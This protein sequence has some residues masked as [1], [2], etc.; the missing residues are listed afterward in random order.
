MSTNEHGLTRA[1]PEIEQP[2]MDS[3]TMGMKTVVT[4][5]PSPSMIAGP[6]AQFDSDLQTNLT[7]EPNGKKVQY[8]Q[9]EHAP[10]L[11]DNQAVCQ[12]VDQDQKGGDQPSPPLPHV[13]YEIGLEER[14][15]PE[16]DTSLA[17]GDW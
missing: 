7:G 12:V 17:G 11:L 13:G 1:D 5:G 8:L 9:I 14:P 16:R 4:E 6:D 3:C 10:D 15:F 2:P